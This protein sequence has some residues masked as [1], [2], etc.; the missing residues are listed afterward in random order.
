[1]K[2]LPGGK[3]MGPFDESPVKLEGWTLRH[4]AAVPR[5]KPTIEDTA[6][7]LLFASAAHETAPYWVGDILAHAVLHGSYHRGQVSLLVRDAG[8]QPQ[9]TDF[10]AFVRGAPAATRASVRSA[11]VHDR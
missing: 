5:G 10:I 6:K 3:S 4:L 11:P 2:L 1:M 7:A 8:A 9:P